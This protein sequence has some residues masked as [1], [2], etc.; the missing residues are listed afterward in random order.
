MGAN[1]ALLLLCF[2]SSTW[3]AEFSCFKDVPQVSAFR[4]SQRNVDEL[5]LEHVEDLTHWLI[6]TAYLRCTALDW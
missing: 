1:N 3:Q 4:S 2:G 5:L 6:D